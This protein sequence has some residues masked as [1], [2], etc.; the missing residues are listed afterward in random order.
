MKTEHTS[1]PW[2]S[3]GLTVFADGHGASTF[4]IVAEVNGNLGNWSD[5]LPVANARLIASAPELLEALREC[6]RVIRWA[7]QRSVGRV[8]ADVVGGWLHQAEK[9]NAAIAKAEGRS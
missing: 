3:Q 5:P 2:Q 1:G 7:A 6:E 4:K 8:R 9:A